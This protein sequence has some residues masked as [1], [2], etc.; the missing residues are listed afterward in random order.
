MLPGRPNID[1]SV[2]LRLAV[3]GK[4]PL[5]PSLRQLSFANNSPSQLAK[6]LPYIGPSLRWVD[7]YHHTA[8]ATDLAVLRAISEASPSLRS[9]FLNGRFS[10]GWVDAVAACKS[11]ET[12][13]IENVWGQSSFDGLSSLPRL[14]DLSISF[15]GFTFSP[16]STIPGWSEGFSPFAQLE[17][18]QISGDL[19]FL[20]YISSTRLKSINIQSFIGELSQWRKCMETLTTTACYAN[21][22]R[23]ISVCLTFPATEPPPIGIMYLME[24]FLRLGEL[25]EM[26]LRLYDV[27]ECQSLSDED[28]AQLA[29]AWPN[30]KTLRISPLPDP[31]PA[32]HSTF[33][34]LYTM[35]LHC[36]QLTHLSLT[37]DLTHLPPR[38]EIPVLSHRLRELDLWKSTTSH[39][40]DVVHLL[41]RIFPSLCAVFSWDDDVGDSIIGELD[42]LHQLCRGAREHVRVQLEQVKNA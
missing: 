28:I 10:V 5:L 19:S 30:L 32:P 11:L 17:T 37:L 39:P 40:L 15:H 27:A 4:F 22:L 6:I 13:D 29:S 26:D 2:F 8:V 24:P 1:M 3:L 41:D 12:L 7:V 35:A 18:L 16:Q 42:G 21:S 20:P 34:S 25:E 9:L 38:H 23:S 31:G 14:C 33:A 36:S